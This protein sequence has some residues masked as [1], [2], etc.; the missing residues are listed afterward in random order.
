MAVNLGS[1]SFELKVSIQTMDMGEMHAMTVLLDLGATGLFVNADFVTQNC[2]MTKL[3]SRPIPV[4]KVDRLPNEVGSISE[5]IEVVLQYCNH[6]EQAIFMV[7]SLRK[8]DLI[9]GL[10]WL[11]EHNPNDDSHTIL[12]T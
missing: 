10:T 8:Q 7:T 12:K 5:V 6:S 1:S 11:Q 2:L 4:Y 9:L 3:L